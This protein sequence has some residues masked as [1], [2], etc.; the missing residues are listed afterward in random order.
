MAVDT[1]QVV[2][3]HIGTP[4]D[5]SRMLSWNSTSDVLAAINESLT[6]R[7]QVSG[8]STGAT[9]EAEPAG[10]LPTATRG[11]PKKGS[12]TK[13]RAK[14]SKPVEASE[15]DTDDVTVVGF[16]MKPTV[17]VP[18]FIAAAIMD[19][20]VT[21]PEEL[22]LLIVN[23]IKQRASEDP[24]PSRA[25]IRAEAASYIP[26]WVLSVAV[27]SRR[28]RDRQSEVAASNAYSKRSDEWAKSL[29]LKH[30][31]VRA[32]SLIRTDDHASTPGRTEDAIRNLSTL[33]ERQAANAA[34]SSPQT[35]KTG[36]DSF[37]PSTKRMVLF[38]SERDADRM[39]RSRPVQSFSD[40]LTLSNV[41]YV[42]NHI[43]HFLRNT[44]GRDAFIP[45]GF[46]AAIRTASFTADTPDRP[47]AFSLFCC[48]PQ[49]FARAAAIGREASD[50]ASTL[51]QMQLKT[52]DTTTGFSEK[53]IKSMTKLNFTVPKDFHELARLIENMSGVLELLSEPIP[54]HTHV[55][56]VE[57]FPDQGGRLHTGD[58]R[59][60]A[61]ADPQ[62][63]AG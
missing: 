51:V 61:H 1:K 54:A 3:R 24:D 43:H 8:V 19:T 35:S 36:F 30:L 55:G 29:H 13:H 58:A 12:G 10:T 31:A 41:A 7:A 37:P 5:W 6:T 27:N 22:A 44:K 14:P 49:T 28:T 57:P 53:D 23:A 40:I 46:C 52:T 2:E 25:T 56:R 63:R 60:L 39:I 20:Y 45:M 26:R 38:V 11:R 16:T 21:A 59:Q 48:G 34:T 50:H 32:R 33:L 47:G 42:Q 15:D 4:F 18:A 62:P 17:P 9:R